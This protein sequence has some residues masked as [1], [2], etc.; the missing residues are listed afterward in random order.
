MRVRRKDKEVLDPGAVLDVLV[1]GEVARVAM[2][3]ADGG[4]YVVPLSYA[5]LPPADGEPLRIVVHGAREG[6]KI[7]ALRRDPRVCVEVTVAAETI[8]AVRACDVS[9][10]FRSVVAFGRAA[11]LEEPAARA[12]A[13]A[14][15][16]ARYAPG[17]PPIDEG[18]ARKVAIVEIRIDAATCKQSP[19][20]RAGSGA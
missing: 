15:I 13:L 5:V 14:A 8:P 19:P 6:R 11:F 1:R 18:E 2:I 17:S 9:V 16:A 12:R 20:P 4:P 10:R 7:D 3:D